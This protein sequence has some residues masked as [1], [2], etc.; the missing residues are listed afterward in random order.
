ML[1]ICRKASLTVKQVQEDKIR[2]IS[3]LLSINLYPNFNEEMRRFNAEAE[4]TLA[5]SRRVRLVRASACFSLRWKS[6]GDMIAGEMKRRHRK[7]V[8]AMNL[9]FYKSKGHG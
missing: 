9:T 7:L 3:L 8:T 1:Q 6:L 5:R 2:M 4:I